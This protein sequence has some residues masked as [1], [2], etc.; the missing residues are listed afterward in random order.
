MNHKRGMS[1][2]LGESAIH[3]YAGVVR[4]EGGVNLHTRGNATVF[5]ATCSVGEAFFKSDAPAGMN[6]HA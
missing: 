5:P 2:A 6:L 3:A 4:P 1:L